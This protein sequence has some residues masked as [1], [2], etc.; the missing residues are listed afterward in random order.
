MS[1]EPN[2]KLLL[3]E[4]VKAIR[5][6]RRV[7]VSVLNEQVIYSEYIALSHI[8]RYLEE[9]PGTP[10]IYVSELAERMEIATS[11]VSRMLN[12]IERKGFITRTVNAKDRRNTYVCLTPAGS[13]ILADSTREMGVLWKRL[14]KRMGDEDTRTLIELWSKL[15]II[16]E[17][18]MNC[19]IEHEK[20]GNIERGSQA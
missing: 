7:K 2:E 13:K 19:S 11:A 4:L 3:N 5:R 18:E 14:I 10:G 1:N 9:H 17:E 16:M 15:A 6:M 8:K 20:E 12:S